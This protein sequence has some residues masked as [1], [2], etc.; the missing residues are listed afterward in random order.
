MDVQRVLD[1]YKHLDTKIA[2]KRKSLNKDIDR[3]SNLEE[4]LMEFI[5]T[6]KLYIPIEDLIKYRDENGTVNEI[7]LI[8]SDNCYRVWVAGDIADITEDGRYYFSDYTEGIYSYDEE[9]GLYHHHYHWHES[10][11]DKIVGF[12]NLE[13]DDK[14]FKETTLLNI[15]ENYVGEECLS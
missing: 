11:G 3:F 6:N 4:R 9:D 7:T 2:T 15:I 13:I 14:V 10:E 5:I 1:E 12:M 8:D